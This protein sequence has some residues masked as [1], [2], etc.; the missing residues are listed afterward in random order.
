LRLDSLDGLRGVAIILVLLMHH[1]LF[2]NGWMGV[3][4]FFVLS[5][6]LITQ[7][8]RAQR[9]D[10]FY[11]RRFYIKRAT[12]I[13]PPLILTISLAYIFTPGASVLVTLGYLFSLSGILELTKYHIT[14]LGPLWSL[15][16]EEHFYL[17]WPFAVR[18]LPRRSLI[19]VLFSLIVCTQLLRMVVSHPMPM[20]EL[21]PIYFL[22][23]FRMDE[24][25]FGCLLAVLVE[26]GGIAAGLKAWSRW[27]ALATSALYLFLWIHLGHIYFFPAAH[28]KLFDTLGYGLIALICFFTIAHVR[29]NRDSWASAALSFKP[30]VFIGRISYGIY[31][32]HLLIKSLIMWATGI[33]SEHVAF[34]FDTP[35][36]VLLSWFSFKYYETPIMK[37]GKRRAD[38]YLTPAL[39]VPL[40]RNNARHVPEPLAEDVALAG[41]QR[42]ST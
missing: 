26:S 24:M 39:P 13:L 11:W 29:L 10:Q 20:A 17:L 19:G 30:L 33:G 14:F 42:V 37:W 9:T 27:F 38:A 22:S 31:L 40:E 2:N 41:L 3:D 23:P 36:I 15:A 6:F 5:G 25:A 32:Y 21:T 12:R 35:A 7:I 8:L 34:L 16:V 1:H 18:Y 4:L 28:T